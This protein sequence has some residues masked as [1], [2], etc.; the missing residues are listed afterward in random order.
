MRLVSSPIATL[1]LVACVGT[2]WPQAAGPA[3]AGPAHGTATRAVSL[4]AD[5]ER[6]LAEALRSRDRRALDSM[7][8]EGFTWRSSSGPDPI[9]RE[10]WLTRELSSS[11]DMRVRD[12]WVREDGDLAT[13]SFLLDKVP[14]R[15]A[16][17]TQF[18]VD[19][20]SAGGQLLARHISSAAGAPPP[21]ARPTGRD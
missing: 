2:A 11:G 16:R 21:P 9:E 3:R 20:W 10:A 1:A 6:A 12:L 8:A 4:Y 15:G 17:T 19:L 18:V 13:V 5:R 14:V 7:V